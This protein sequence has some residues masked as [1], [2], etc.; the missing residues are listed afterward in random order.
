[1]PVEEEFIDK[2]PT[3]T[4]TSDIFFINEMQTLWKKNIN[5]TYDE[6]WLAKLLLLF[7]GIYIF[8][9]IVFVNYL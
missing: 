5:K 1:M 8:I 4:T 7:Y 9:I 2:I 6:G 3:I